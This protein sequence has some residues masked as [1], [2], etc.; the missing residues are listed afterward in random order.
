[1]VGTCVEQ[2]ADGRVARIGVDAARYRP[3]LRY[4]VVVVYY[5]RHFIVGFCIRLFDRHCDAKRVADRAR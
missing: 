1:M 3:S 4:L 2:S 5:Q